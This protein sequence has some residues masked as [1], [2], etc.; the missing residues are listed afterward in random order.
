MFKKMIGLMILVGL[1]I[2]GCAA[3]QSSEKLTASGTI[4]A[5]RFD[6]S[7]EIGG[8]LATI[9]YEEGDEVKSGNVLFEL[10][11]EVVVVQR[12]QAL[13]G[14]AVADA[15]LLAA[16]RQLNA[17]QIQ[18]QRTEQGARMM[19][20]QRLQSQPS[21]WNAPI[22]TQFE[23]PGWYYLPEENLAAAE[24]EV[25]QAEEAVAR[26][27]ENLE[28]VQGKASNGDFVA[29]EQALAD[30]RLRFLVAEQ[31]L[32]QA[33]T[34]LNNELLKEMAQKEYDAALSNLETTQRDYDRMLTT[35]AANEVLEARAKLA[36]S[37][38]RLE[39]ALL[40]LDSFQRNDLSLEVEGA[41]AALS[42]AEA[43]V[44][45]A[46]AGQQQAQ[47]ALA[48][49]DLQLK[50]MEVVAPVDGVVM[51]RNVQVGELA[52]AGMTVMTIG[53]LDQVRLTVYVPEDAYGRVEIGQSVR[54]TVD[55][56][57]ERV[58]N[59]TVLRVADEAEF[60]PRNV[61]TVEGRKA[62][63]YAVEIVIANPDGALKPGMPADVDFGVER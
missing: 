8:K 19:E 44:E 24:R 28:T 58:F 30:A 39:N 1:L 9:F 57:P 35:A 43:Q 61:Q 59:G 13:A 16:Q 52:G 17:A 55:S 40:M 42:S 4:S 11:D 2:S 31:T 36:I 23:Q 15:G 46:L 62:T 7:P 49:L 12:E 53:Q 32:N 51:A 6:V 37:K 20:L 21:L 60:T 18:L 33:S 38:T 26:E 3:A 25:A 22:P 54:V 48:L 34:A 41:R 29:M 14:V 56:F 45:Q 10:D 5:E 63:V 27:E 50:K 47:A